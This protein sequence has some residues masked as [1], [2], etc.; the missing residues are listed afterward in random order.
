MW[1]SL[2]AGIRMWSQNGVRQ[3]FPHFFQTKKKAATQ[4][5]RLLLHF[6]QDRDHSFRLM[7]I[8]YLASANQSASASPAFVCFSDHE[9][10]LMMQSIG[11]TEACITS[12]YSRKLKSSI[13]ALKPFQILLGF[14]LLFTGSSMQYWLLTPKRRELINSNTTFC[15]PFLSFVTGQ[16][17]ALNWIKQIGPIVSQKLKDWKSIQKT[18][19]QILFP[20]PIW[21]PRMI[22]GGI[23]TTSGDRTGVSLYI[24]SPTDGLNE[25]NPNMKAIS[26]DDRT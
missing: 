12:A 19:T 11:T 7:G 13:F 1:R 21:C 25:V 8:H 16:D 10:E 5:H 15:L 17:N 9:T 14:S 4:V 26:T 24:P 22:A 20:Y 2:A 3:S 6:E 23:F 18:P